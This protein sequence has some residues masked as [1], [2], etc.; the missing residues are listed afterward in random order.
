[1]NAASVLD[2]IR[3]YYAGCNAAD[4]AAMQATFCEDV[5]HYFTH[6]A[7][8]RGAAALAE[9]WARMQPRIAGHWTVDHG[10]AQDD[11]AVI[12][13]TLRWTPPGTREAS[14]AELMRGA[15]WY[16]LRGGR[17]AEI[18]AYYLNRH[19]PYARRD[20]ELDGFDYAGR[21]YAVLPE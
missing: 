15:E 9:H 5:V 8:V 3:R 1:M 14:Q 4:R 6:H 2:L 18:R 10:I 12:E 13:W 20:F 7:P 17:I 16:R 19:A 11:E 21:G